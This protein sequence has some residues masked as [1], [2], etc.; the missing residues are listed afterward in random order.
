MFNKMR[1]VILLCPEN[2]RDKEKI[3]SNF[4]SVNDRLQ[5]TTHRFMKEY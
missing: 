3:I 5:K 2:W 1:L 4:Q